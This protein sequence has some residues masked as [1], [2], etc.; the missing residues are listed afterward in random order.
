MLFKIIDKLFTFEFVKGFQYKIS[1]L[2]LF[3]HILPIKFSI[4]YPF[5]SISRIV[6]HNQ[7]VGFFT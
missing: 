1:L 6:I 3:F 2:N 5:Q 4:N 7:F